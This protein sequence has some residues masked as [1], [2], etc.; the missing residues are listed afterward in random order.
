MNVKRFLAVVMASTM[1][2]GSTVTAF[3]DDPDPNTGSATGTGVN[4]GHLETDGVFTAV[5]PTSVGT[6]FDFTIDPEDILSSADKFTDGT[7]LGDDFGNDDLVY[8]KNTGD[9]GTSYSSTSDAVKV[10][11]KNYVDVD[12]TV[13]ATIEDAASG[14][15]II[16][17]VGSED[18]LDAATT[19]SLYLELAVG[20]KKGA[21]LSTG[22][23]VT[24]KLAGVPANF[25]T[26]Y[27][28]GDSGFTG[29]KLVE[30][31]DADWDDH[32][33][34]VT[35]SGKVKG[36]D[37]TSSVVA[38]EVTLTWTVS[39]HVDYNYISAG[40][41]SASSKAVT[42]ALPDG[43][44]VSSVKLTLSGSDTTLT[45]G[46]QYTISGTTLTFTKFAASW[47]GGTVTVT[48]SDGKTDTL[49][50]Q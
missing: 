31:S 3:A 43:V 19:P 22:G 4:T 28:A 5:L 32:E 27:Q 12:I 14:K 1:V 36:G 34:E 25:T 40:S 24:E 47:V 17:M 23:K 44:T 9:S 21:V 38:P 48:Y 29:Y 11:A 39:Q 45:K 15:T 2:L 41:I 8:F 10:G 26:A 16:P 33:V 18:D 7:A 49:T 37:V 50:C 13:N 6:K 35:L 42:M 30:A 46:N 20:T